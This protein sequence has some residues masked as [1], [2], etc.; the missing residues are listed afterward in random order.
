M[1]SKICSNCN[2]R[3]KII[4]S[5]GFPVDCTVCGTSGWIPAEKDNNAT[6][7]QTNED[8]PIYYKKIRKI[9]R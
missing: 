3:K 8:F 2:G 5:G 1:L 4:G 6:S 9:K 7:L